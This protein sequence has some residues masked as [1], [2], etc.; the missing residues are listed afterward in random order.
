MLKNIINQVT[1]RGEEW[2][3]VASELERAVGIVWECAE[4]L[5]GEAL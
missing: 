1:Q 5:R 2:K 4:K 3:G